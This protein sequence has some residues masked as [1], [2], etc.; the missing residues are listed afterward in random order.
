MLNVKIAMINLLGVLALANAIVQASP[1]GALSPDHIVKSSHQS[2]PPSSSSSVDLSL[3]QF[4]SKLHQYEINRKNLLESLLLNK[5]P[6]DEYASDN[7]A[8]DDESD[9]DQTYAD[10]DEEQLEATGSEEDN[11]NNNNN[12]SERIANKLS[13]YLS[14]NKRSAPRR[15]FIG[16]RTNSVDDADSFLTA[17]SGSGTDR[18]IDVDKKNSRRHLFLGKRQIHR[19]FI[20]KRGDIKRIFIG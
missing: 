15:I 9:S 13:S 12:L 17:G 18:F 5:T 8:A 1:A 4:L 11:N 16:K 10:D 6:L 2:L 3:G 7:N 20:G 19:I 14:T